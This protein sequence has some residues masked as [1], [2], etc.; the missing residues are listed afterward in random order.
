MALA[1]IAST[2]IF[3]NPRGQI[4][5]YGWLHSWCGQEHTLAT[6]S[7][8]RGREWRTESWNPTYTKCASFPSFRA[9]PCGRWC[10]WENFPEKKCKAH[11][12]SVVLT[13]RRLWLV[14]AFKSVLFYS[15]AWVTRVLEKLHIETLA[16]YWLTMMAW[17]YCVLV[18][19]QACGRAPHFLH[20]PPRGWS[21]CHFASF[22]GADSSSCSL[23]ETPWAFMKAALLG[24]PRFF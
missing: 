11:G 1:C 5:L 22:V 18:P 7:H 21:R 23:D 16:S 9:V 15:D 8:G 19:Y 12:S 2:R 24:L 17:S 13:W 10:W 4:W 3:Q 14:H 6:K 20:T